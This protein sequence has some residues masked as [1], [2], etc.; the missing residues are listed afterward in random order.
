M[1]GRAATDPGPLARET[2][3]FGRQSLVSTRIRGSSDSFGMAQPGSADE[4]GQIA[5]MM[6][7]SRR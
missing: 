7:D 5:S 2:C 3:G 4:A 6:S 1:L